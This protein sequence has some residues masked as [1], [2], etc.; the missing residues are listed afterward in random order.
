MDGHP[1][2]PA[3]VPVSVWVGGSGCLRP[4][5]IFESF[6]FEVGKVLGLG[7]SKYRPP[8]L[9]SGWVSRQSGTQKCLCRAPPGVIKKKP[10]QQI[11]SSLIWGFIFS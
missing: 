1:L 10:D 6:C 5:K 2:P 7:G 3:G 8:P 4:Q 11:T 9:G